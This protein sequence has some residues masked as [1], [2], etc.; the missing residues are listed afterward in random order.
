MINVEKLL[1][2]FKFLISSFSSNGV[3]MIK[4]NNDQSSMNSECQFESFRD[5]LH[6]KH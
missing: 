2:A 5:E 6:R 1:G 4:D 3:I